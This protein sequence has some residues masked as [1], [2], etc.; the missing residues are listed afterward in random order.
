MEDEESA[1]GESGPAKKGKKRRKKE[2]VR[3]GRTEVVSPTRVR[4]GL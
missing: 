2:W 3:D 1:D 4:K